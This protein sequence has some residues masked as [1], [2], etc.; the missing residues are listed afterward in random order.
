MINFT[1]YIFLYLVFVIGPSFNYINAQ[2]YIGALNDSIKKYKAAEYQKALDFGFLALDFFKDEDEMS[3]EFVNTNYYLGETYFYLEEYKTSFE[4]LS[5][6]LELY[7]LLK[8]NQRRNKD[9]VKPPWVLI[10]MGNVFYQKKDYRIEIS[11]IK[12][13]KMKLYF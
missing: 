6:T 7:D 4:Y 10:I 9:V 3:L 1:K 8:P 12:T 11:L 2:S 13:E 5:Q